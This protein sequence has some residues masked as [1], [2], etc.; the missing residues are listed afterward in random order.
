[1]LQRMLRLHQVALGRSTV[2]L[3]TQI[4]ASVGHGQF[5]VGF[6]QFVLGGL[7]EPGAGLV[8]SGHRPITGEQHLTQHELSVGQVC[9]SGH[10]QPAQRC[11]GVRRNTRCPASIQKAEVVG[12]CGGMLL[13]GSTQMTQRLRWV[14]GNP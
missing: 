8:R 5:K 4:A 2:G 13:S 14:Y 7:F 11:G 9:L 6:R 1:M 12:R 3:D 10:A